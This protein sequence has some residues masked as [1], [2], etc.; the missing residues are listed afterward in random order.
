MAVW[1]MLLVLLGLTIA[2][3]RLQLLSRYSIPAALLI[4][5]TKAGLVL[6]YFMHLK[7]EGRLLKGMLLVTVGLLAVLI[8]LTFVDVWFRG[9]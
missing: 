2:V 5:S 6:I 9:A 7:Q 4:A 8:S 3:A 1:A